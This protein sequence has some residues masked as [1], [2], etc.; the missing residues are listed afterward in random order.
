[1]HAHHYALGTTVGEALLTPTRIYT[2]AVRALRESLGESLHALCHVTGG[3]VPEN[4][5]R[6]LPDGVA[7]R[8]DGARPWP[9]RFRVIAEGGPVE[10]DEMRRPFN[11]GIGLIAVVDP[12]RAEDALAALRAAGEDAWR[13]G[14]LEPEANAK[15]HVRYVGDPEEVHR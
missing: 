10:L 13:L 4:L 14:S 1:M 3:G 9:A 2:R 11:L 5:P 7:A 8:I 12:T 6:V 15:P